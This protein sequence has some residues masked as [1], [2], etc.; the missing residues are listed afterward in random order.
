ML[1]SVPAVALH[2]T[3]QRPIVCI[4]STVR[5]VSTLLLYVYMCV[6]KGKMRKDKPKRYTHTHTNVHTHYSTSTQ[7]PLNKHYY[8]HKKSAHAAVKKAERQPNS[9]MVSISRRRY[10]FA[11]SCLAAV[12]AMSEAFTSSSHGKK[13]FGE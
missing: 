5:R 11:A 8:I 10:A 2:S 3:V 7:T 12:I 1:Y 6:R 9:T 13:R 4:Y